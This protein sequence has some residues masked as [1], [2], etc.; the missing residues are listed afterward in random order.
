MSRPWVRRLDA[1]QRIAAAGLVGPLARR[2]F[3]QE[4]RAAVVVL[5]TERGFGLTRACGLMRISRSLYRYRSRRPDGAP[6]RAR[7]EEVTAIKRRYGYRRVYMRR[8]G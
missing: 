2:Y 6:L 4:K 8:E 3:T 1:N 5:M 7:I